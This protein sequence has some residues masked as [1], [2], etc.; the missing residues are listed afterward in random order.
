MALVTRI[1]ETSA[2]DMPNGCAQLA[3]VVREYHADGFWLDGY[4]PGHLHTYDEA[5]RRQFRA[6]SGGKELPTRFDPVHDPVARQYL[7]WHDQYFVDL[8]DRMRGAIRAENPEAVLFANYS[9]NRTWYYPEMYMGEYPAAY[10]K[11]VDVPSVEFYWDVPGDA[12]YQQFCCAFMQGVTDNRGGSV[13]I[14]ALRARRLGRLL[15][16]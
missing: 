6:A 7:A 9:A 2:A 11:A 3:Y 1:S 15:A 4:A 12:L 5:T 10:C 14:P 8:A 16:G 13:W